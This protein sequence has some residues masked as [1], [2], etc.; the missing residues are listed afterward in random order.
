MRL[1]TED[2]E[3]SEHETEV[4]GSDLPAPQISND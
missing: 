2:L 3:K 1:P 4:G